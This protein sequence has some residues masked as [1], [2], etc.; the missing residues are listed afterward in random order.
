M[1]LN[2]GC[3]IYVYSTKGIVIMGE[4]LTECGQSAG[5]LSISSVP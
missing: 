5:D 2:L 1:K 3:L 4:V